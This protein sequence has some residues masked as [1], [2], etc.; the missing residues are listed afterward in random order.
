MVMLWRLFYMVVVL[1]FEAVCLCV[2][3]CLRGIHE[4]LLS[5]IL[6][7]KTLRKACRP[8]GLVWPKGML[9]VVYEY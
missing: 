9:F 3:G 6:I 7:N 2:V 4:G 5:H 8:L 1:G